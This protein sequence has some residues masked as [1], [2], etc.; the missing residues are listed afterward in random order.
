MKNIDQLKNHLS[1]LFIGLI[2]LGFCTSGASQQNIAWQKS[3]GTAYGDEAIQMF[4]DDAGNIVILGKEIHEDFTGNPRSYLLVAKYDLSGNEIWKKYHD[5]AYETFSIPVDY[6]FGQHFYTED[7][8]QKFISLVVSIGQRHLLYKINDASGDYFS[9]SEIFSDTY[10][11][12]RTGVEVYANQQCSYVQSCYG[13]DSLIVQ[14]INPF[15]IIGFDPVAWTFELRQNIR[16]APIQGHYDFNNQDITTDSVGNVYLLTQ[17]ER[18]DFQFCTDCG[19]AFIDAHCYIFKFDTSGQLIMKVKLKTA[20]AVISNMRFVA[21]HDGKLLVR[22]D[23]INSA[24]TA[25]IS[26]LYFLNDDLTVT[27]QFSL[28]RQYNIITADHDDNLFTCTNVYDA[29]DPNIK[30]LSDVLVSKFNSSGVQQWKS[31]FGGSS[32]DYPKGLVLTNDGGLAFFANTQSTDFDIAENHGDQDMWLVKLSEHVTT[33]TLD[34]SARPGLTIFPNPCTD[35]VN[36]SHLTEPM[37]MVI[38]NPDGRIVIQKSVDPADPKINVQRLTAGMYFIKGAD[39]TG[40]SFTSKV[41]KL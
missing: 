31:Y 29:N 41:L 1:W 17:I 8:G 26:S 34:H 15:P 10:V 28:D 14:K 27:H 20:K 25:V 12:D 4:N 33:G 2:I 13:P 7:N 9:Y 11:V 6:Y 5:L 36:I 21:N 38:Y 40:K 37:H 23:D 32:F 18:W 16:T 35:V 19:D 24:V 3:I 30:G 39:K 22:I